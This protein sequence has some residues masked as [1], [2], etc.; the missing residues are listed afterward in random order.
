MIWIILYVI[1][2]AIC[3]GIILYVEDIEFKDNDSILAVMV[4]LVWPMYL[5]VCILFGLGHC[6]KLLLEKIIKTK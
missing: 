5:A 2:T 6:I 1:C 4:S 3:C